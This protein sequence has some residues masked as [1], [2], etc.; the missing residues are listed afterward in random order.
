MVD[1]EE[2]YYLLYNSQICRLCC[3]E[4]ANGSPL[5]TGK[6]DDVTSLINTYLPLKVRR[7]INKYKGKKKS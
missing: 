7:K 2:E 4:N 6:E 5:Y 1:Y 3:V